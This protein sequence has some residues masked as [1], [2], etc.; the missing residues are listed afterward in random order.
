[1]LMKAGG[2]GRAVEPSIGRK[3]LHKQPH[4]STIKG[5]SGGPQGLSGVRAL[6]SVGGV[7]VDSTRWFRAVCS[8][9]SRRTRAD[10]AVAGLPWAFGVTQS[11]RGGNRRNT[12]S[13]SVWAGFEP[14]TPGFSVRCS[15]QLSYHDLRALRFDP[16]SGTHRADRP[17]RRGR[18]AAG[19]ATSDD[20]AVL[21]R[22]EKR[23]WESNPL[24]PICSRL[25]GRLAPASWMNRTESMPPPGV[26]PGL[27]PS[28][29]RV[30]PSHSGDGLI[31]VSPPARS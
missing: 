24:P 6:G 25:P 10:R 8:V 23:G 2:I 15:L 13:R 14:A 7:A 22:R 27:R 1:M 5:H 9:G 26:E 31:G 11:R 21:S 29:G 4:P 20:P 18:C 28:Q 19:P 30:P 3:E 16:M 17:G 12:C